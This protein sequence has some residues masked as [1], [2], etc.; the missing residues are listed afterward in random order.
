ML[1]D[2]LSHSH[3]FFDYLLDLDGISYEKT[4]N[5]SADVMTFSMNLVIAFY[6]LC[7]NWNVF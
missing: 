3:N 4:T 7:V 5:F 6:S 1:F 2:Y